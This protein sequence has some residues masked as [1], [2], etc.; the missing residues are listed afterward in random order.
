[1]TDQHIYYEIPPEK[2]YL[3]R[4]KLALLSTGISMVLLGAVTSLSVGIPLTQNANN[5]K[6]A[7]DFLSKFPLIDR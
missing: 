3:S 5:L 7:G 2:N 1:M 6:R 4:R